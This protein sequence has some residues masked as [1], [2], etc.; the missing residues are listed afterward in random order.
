M[1]YDLTESMRPNSQ[2]LEA[3]T[4]ARRDGQMTADGS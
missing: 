4:V 1:I 2:L 3:W